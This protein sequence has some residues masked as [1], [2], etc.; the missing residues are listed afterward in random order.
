MDILVIPDTQVV[1]GSPTEHLTALGNYTVEHKPDVIVHIGDHWDM[2]S[3]SSYDVGKKAAENARYQEDINAG[4]DALYAFM[5]PTWM[6][7]HRRYLHKK[8]LYNPRKI[9]LIGNH[10]NR[11]TRYVN[12]YP[13]L[14]GKLSFSDLMLEEYGWEVYNFLEVVEINGVYFSHY[15][16]NPD[17]VA[18]RPFSSSID[19]QAKT[20]GFSFVAGHLPGLAMSN[21]RYLQN[22]NVVRGVV[23]GSFYLHD[24]SYQNPPQGNN[25]WRGAI[26][27][28]NVNNGNFTLEELPIEWLMDNYI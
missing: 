8:K 9:F 14:E 18:R 21:P 17:S 6:Y 2:H 16:L 15:F 3:L 12:D 24:F 23:A 10:E 27:L 19:F 4:N 22:G 25:Y 13:V 7:N 1:P 5:Q 11:I 28:K 26:K 20:L